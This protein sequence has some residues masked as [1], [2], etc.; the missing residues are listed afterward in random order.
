MFKRTNLLQELLNK[1]NVENL[2]HGAKEDKMGDT[3]EDY[4]VSL[5]I[6]NANK[7]KTE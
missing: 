3:I 7:L 1:Y 4:C 2:T 5:H 6:I